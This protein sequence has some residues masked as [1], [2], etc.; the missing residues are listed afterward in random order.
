M[1]QSQDQLPLGPIV[2]TTPLMRRI[3]DAGRG[4]G[5]NPSQ[6]ELRIVGQWSVTLW[7]TGV[8]AFQRS[9]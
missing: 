2:V 5:A 4:F 6:R 8:P 7:Q 9:K 1:Q 3:D